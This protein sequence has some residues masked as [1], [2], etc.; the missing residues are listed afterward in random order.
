MK[1]FRILIVDDDADFAQSLGDILEI[2][3]HEVDIAGDGLTGLEMFRANSPDVVFLDFKMPGK[4]GIEC[5]LEMRELA[6]DTKIVLMTGF[7]LG[8]LLQDILEPLTYRVIGHPFDISNLMDAVRSVRPDGKVLLSGGDQGFL[9]IIRFRLKDN[10]YQP[11]QVSAGVPPD[12]AIV[13]IRLPLLDSLAGFYDLRNRFPELPMIVITAFAEQRSEDLNTVRGMLR[14]RI[15]RKP[16]DPA[17]L[18]EVI[19]E[20]L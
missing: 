1:N 5:L 17:R 6:P 3:G 20:A 13:D 9:K 7:S 14:N 16:I 12:L 4:N 18:L 11:P 15:L 8:A 2:V 19:G 10:G